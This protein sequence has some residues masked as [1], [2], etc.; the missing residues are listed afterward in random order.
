MT[1][2]VKHCHVTLKLRPFC[3]DFIHITMCFYKRNLILFL[4]SEHFSSTF[5][6]PIWY[7]TSASRLLTFYYS[8]Q[9]LGQLGTILGSSSIFFLFFFSLPK[10][11]FI[12]H[13]YSLGLRWV[14]SL[15][16]IWGQRMF[17]TVDENEA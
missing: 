8:W 17:P 14:L 3:K 4:F 11:S 1:L 12:F 16:L 13:L 2:I 6:G 10:N 15:A 5:W 9:W 7:H